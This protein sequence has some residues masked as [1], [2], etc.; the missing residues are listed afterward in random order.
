MGLSEFR[1]GRAAALPTCLGRM[2]APARQRPRQA[3]G[4]LL[5]GLCL[6]L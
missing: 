3:S 6:Q 4:R 1:E 5:G 2:E